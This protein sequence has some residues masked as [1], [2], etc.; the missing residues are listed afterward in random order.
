MCGLA[1]GTAALPLDHRL[2]G[3]APGTVCVLLWWKVGFKDGFQHQHRC[4]HAD[5]ITHLSLP[6][7][8]GMYTLLMGAGR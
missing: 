1:H 3:V 5:P 2:L 6:L 4:C 7:A 8:F